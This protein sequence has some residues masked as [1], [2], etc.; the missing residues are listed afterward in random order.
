MTDRGYK[1]LLVIGDPHVESR[2][3]GF[4]KD[5]YPQVILNKLR[6]CMNYAR[7]NALLP[8]L[9]GD[10]FH[11]PRDNPNWI[12]GDLID[13]FSVP[14]IGIYGNH[15]CRENAMD[16]NDSISV[17]A[18]A[19]RVKLLCEGEIWQGRMAGRDV[20]VGGTPWGKFLPDRFDGADDGSASKPLVF[21]LAHHDVMVP[22]YEEQGRFKPREIPGVDV[23]I[24]G[25]IHRRLEEVAV[26][27]TLWLTPGNISRRNRGD[28]TRDH[29]PAVLQIDVT[30]SGWQRRM[31]EV[32]H[33]PFDA[34]FYEQVVKV[35]ELA[36]GSAFVA[37]LAELQA[38]RTETGAGLMAFLE[39]NLPQFEKAVADEI[40]QLA[41]EVTGNG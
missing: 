19:N 34:V 14:V 1:G 2:V 41:R 8:A 7:D 16:E 36:A 31:V 30:V 27:N 17:L 5:S 33:E 21:W 35:A 39:N 4:R 40:L 28:A 20:I 38:R 37:G 10:L 25:H 11:L 6:W 3:P 29:V 32:P 9:L 23:V 13:L 26:G 18:R 24:N 15:D 22:G 12:L